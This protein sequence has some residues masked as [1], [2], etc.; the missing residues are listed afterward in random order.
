MAFVKVPKPEPDFRH[1]SQETRLIHTG[2][3]MLRAH[4][5]QIES[6]P[7]RGPTR[8]CRGRTVYTEEQAWAIVDCELTGEPQCVKCS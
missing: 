8:W 7:E 4:G 6:R 3:L 5:F 1:P 2:D